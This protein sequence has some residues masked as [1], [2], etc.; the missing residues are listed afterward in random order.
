MLP[1]VAG[2]QATKRQI[3][4]YTLLLLVLT[5]LFPATGAVGWIYLGAVLALGLGFVALAARLIRT[6][7][8][9]GAVGTYVYSLAYLVL[10]FGAIALD[11]S[12]S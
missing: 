11:G 10:L 1:V 7:G 8:T 6:P 9:K 4:L 3:L 12:L 5:C 2:V